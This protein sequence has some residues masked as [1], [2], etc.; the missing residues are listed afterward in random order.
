MAR[1]T[2]IPNDVPFNL[3]Q[4]IW[5]NGQH[6]NRGTAIAPGFLHHGLRSHVLLA[7]C[8]A[9]ELA[10]ERHGSLTKDQSNGVFTAAL[11]KTLYAVG[12]QN[13]TYANL[14]SRLPSLTVGLNP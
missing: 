10:R 8:G 2:E 12:A 9:K 4:E 5:S 13:V 7:A 11:L 6:E 14:F 1:V 3:D